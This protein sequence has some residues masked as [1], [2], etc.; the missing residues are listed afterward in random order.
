MALR[1]RS[2]AIALAWMTA[3]GAT[4][5]SAA[6]RFAEHPS[7]AE[8]AASLVRYGPRATVSALW[9]KRRWDYVSD[10]IGAGDAAWVA[11][12]PRLAAGAD[13]GIAE[14]LPVALAFALPRNAP[15]VLA[16]LASG[17]FDV[18]EV[19]GAPFIEN[20]VSD[21]PAYRRQAQAAVLRVAVPRLA[22]VRAA[23][24]RALESER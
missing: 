19:C 16:A 20:T 21:I 23:C 13:A 12:A 3:A 4:A 15:A 22:S 14:D 17:A 7:A 18:D 9:D 24:L 11:L 5:A 10:R 1:S 6:P 2:M 8:V